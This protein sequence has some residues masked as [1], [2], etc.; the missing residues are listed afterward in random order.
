MCE[1]VEGKVGAKKTPIGLMPNDGDIDLS[2]L[3]IPSEDMKELTDVDPAEWRAEIPDIEA[4]F[5]TFGNH[6]PERL[7][8]QLKDLITRLG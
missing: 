7:R 5:D 4:H 6:L 1:R 8:S 2:G 3:K